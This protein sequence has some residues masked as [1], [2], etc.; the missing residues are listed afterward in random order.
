MLTTRVWILS[1]LLGLY[2]TSVHAGPLTTEKLEVSTPTAIGTSEVCLYEGA[3]YA[4]GEKTAK[5]GPCEEC[6][7]QPP[8]VVCSMIKCPVQ[9]GCRI[10]Q[11][12]NQC[13][14]DYKC[15][16]EY[17]GQTY[18]NGERLDTRDE[19]CKVCYCKGGEVMCT[20]ISCYHRDDCEPR[21]VAG[22]CCPKYDHCPLKD[23]NPLDEKDETLSTNNRSYVY[24]PK[25]E[26]QPWLLTKSVEVKVAPTIPT[27]IVS[28]SA[29]NITSSSSETTTQNTD[30]QQQTW[31]NI[32]ISD[33]LTERRT[34]TEEDEDS[35]RIN[36]YEN[37]E[38]Y[39]NFKYSTTENPASVESNTDSLV[40]DQENRTKTVDTTNDM[41][42]TE[43]VTEI[44]AEQ[45][46]VT[47]TGTELNTVITE[48]PYTDKPVTIVFKET[49]VN[50]FTT[51][52]DG[53]YNKEGHTEM[54]LHFATEKAGKINLPYTTPETPSSKNTEESE[55]S[56]E[57]LFSVYELT[58]EIKSYISTSPPNMETSSV[59]PNEN[60][61]V[62]LTEN[63]TAISEADYEITTDASIMLTEGSETRRDPEDETVNRKTESVTSKSSEEIISTTTDSVGHN[64]LTTQSTFNTEN[65]TVNEKKQHYENLML[66]DTS[67]VS[68]GSKREVYGISETNIATVDNDH[69]N[70]YGKESASET[71]TTLSPTET[72]FHLNDEHSFNTQKLQTNVLDLGSKIDNETVDS[73]YN[74]NATEVTDNPG[75][76][77]LSKVA[78]S[79]INTE[80][81]QYGLTNFPNEEQ[82][83]ETTEKTTKHSDL[84]EKQQIDNY[85][86]NVPKENS[87]E[88]SSDEEVGTDANSLKMHSDEGNKNIDDYSYEP[89]VLELNSQLPF[90]QI[91]GH[92]S[93]EILSTDNSEEDKSN[94]WQYGTPESENAHLSFEENL[95]NTTVEGYEEP[96]SSSTHIPLTPGDLKILAEYLINEKIKPT[97]NESSTYMPTEW[98]KGNLT[99][100]NTKIASILS[101][102][103]I[104]IGI[105]NRN[106]SDSIVKL[107]DGNLENKTT[108]L[109]ENNVTTQT[110]ENLLNNK[111][112]A[113]EISNLIK[114]KHNSVEEP[115]DTVVTLPSS[116]EVTNT[117]ANETVNTE[118]IALTE[119]MSTTS[120]YTMNKDNSFSENLNENNQIQQIFNKSL[121]KG[122]SKETSE[123]DRIVDN[124]TENKTE[125]NESFNSIN[126]DENKKNLSLL[127]HANIDADKVIPAGENSSTKN[128]EVDSSSG[129]MKP[130]NKEMYENV[131]YPEENSNNTNTLKNLSNHKKRINPGESDEYTSRKVRIPEMESIVKEPF[132]ASLDDNDLTILKEFLKKHMVIP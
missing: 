51:T 32:I 67:L 59:F 109:Q 132:S 128:N 22:Q 12:V 35:S 93:M 68:V 73:I 14:P 124:N 91:G 129:N 70:S 53:I 71:D 20:S 121:E 34:T 115:E 6:V 112:P 64:D 119:L 82:G 18:N 77:S 56:G 103:N 81:V 55:K 44:N 37:T 117:D 39:L 130:E 69:Q 111:N 125:N 52:T 46:A 36:N 50:E 75:R 100:N 95:N 90:L 107:T 76:L 49:S 48:T 72:T 123:T 88:D 43:I 98:L 58:N 131:F 89:P 42:N 106:K 21:F 33:W 16:C 28:K 84:Q 92:G 4:K 97:K 15:E 41:P 31:N 1:V 120:Y 11:R 110:F 78:D 19:P 27:Q 60:N 38:N 87:E 126:E 23:I 47:G 65:E 127:I 102:A 7:C 80:T 13:C 114:N 79:V 83:V 17:N 26:M 99:S 45:Q 25:R 63:G 94:S 2:V 101:A 122:E 5:P 40:T 9:S 113:T 54:P 30:E 104:S 24:S 57:K 86:T 105:M 10:I 62:F 85:A 96:I 116:L 8:S 118:G 108:L 29:E 61:T 66:K 3:V 74:E